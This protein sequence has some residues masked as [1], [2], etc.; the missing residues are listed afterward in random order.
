MIRKI[1]ESGLN[2]IKK[3]RFRII[4]KK[5]KIIFKF[6]LSNKL[7]LKRTMKHFINTINI[8]LINVNIYLLFYFNLFSKNKL[9]KFINYLI[10]V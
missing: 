1:S 2:L 8:K 3:S 10:K 5:F 9:N 6:K 7:F 4:I